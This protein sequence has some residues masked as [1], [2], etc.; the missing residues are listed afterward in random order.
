MQITLQILVLLY[1]VWTV[2]HEDILDEIVLLK[3]R[4]K[5]G[6]AERNP[7]FVGANSSTSRM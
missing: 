6:S 2:I 7:F 4:K 5:I 3:K 1:L